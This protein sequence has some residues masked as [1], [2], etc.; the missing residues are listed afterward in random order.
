ML[1]RFVGVAPR[2]PEAHCRGGDSNTTLPVALRWAKRPRLH[3]GSPAWIYLTATRCLP[4]A[5]LAAADAADIAREGHR[6]SAWFAHRG[7]NSE[8][9]HVEIRGPDFK[10][11]LTGGTNTLFRLAGSDQRH[12]RLALAEAPIDALSVAAIEDLR[13]DTLYSATGGGMGPRT[14]TV[15]EHLLAGMAPQPGAILVSA[16]DANRAGE[17]YA[18]RHAELAAAAGVAFERLAPPMG[19]DW[20]DVIQAG[21]KA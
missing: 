14:I 1:R 6:G 8:V 9:T 21:R 12:L 5:I 16:T 4:P 18:A 3:Q 19:C 7:A 15:I 10:G 11:S 13:A 2:F 17:R 20:N